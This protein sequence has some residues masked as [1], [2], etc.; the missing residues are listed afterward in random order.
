MEIEFEQDDHFLGSAAAAVGA[1]SCA[2][3]S[4]PSEA[5]AA[6]RFEVTRTPAEW[7]R[8]LGP[9]RFAVLREEDTE[10]AGSSPLDEEKRRGTLRLRRVRPAGLQFGDEV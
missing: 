3:C 5:R 6:E 2:G 7:K 8:R 10:R 9:A 1:S 4:R